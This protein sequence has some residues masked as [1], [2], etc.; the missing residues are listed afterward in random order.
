M[1]PEQL[2]FETTSGAET[3]RLGEQLGALL[4]GDAIITLTGDLGAGKTTF[5]QG[6]GA[7]LGV[8]GAIT[9]PTFVLI[10]RYHCADGRALQHADCYRLANAP[11]EM[12]DAGL[13]D[14][15]LSEDVVVVEWADRI[16]GLLPDEYLDIVFEHGDADR[17]RIT[18]T[19]RGPR[20]VHMLR[21]LQTAQSG[22][23]R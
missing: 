16:P 2:V 22:A 6:L 20:Y 5:T 8:E 9:S 3:Q 10:N 4:A 23:H 17:R 15:F 13:T 11:L 19:A 1:E 12:W 18:L 14:L 21:Q 7:G